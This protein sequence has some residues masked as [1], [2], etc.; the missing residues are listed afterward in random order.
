MEYLKQK[1]LVGAARD[2]ADEVLARVGEAKAAVLHAPAVLLQKVRGRNALA[3]LWPGFRMGFS[4]YACCAAAQAERVGAAGA[5]V[6]WWTQGTAESDATHMVRGPATPSPVQ[7]LHY[8]PIT[9]LLLAIRRFRRPWTGC[10]PLAPW[11]ARCRRPS[12]AWKR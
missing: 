5:L 2:A 3:C 6:H 9:N 10:W 11:T 12:R 1:G 8:T 4:V 7:S